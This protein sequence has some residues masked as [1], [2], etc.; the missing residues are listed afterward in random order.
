M[1]HVTARAREIYP[2]IQNADNALL[3]SAG[4]NETLITVLSRETLNM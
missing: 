2:L 4:D 3:P 1:V